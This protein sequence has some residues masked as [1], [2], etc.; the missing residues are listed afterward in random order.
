MVDGTAA[1]AL[2]TSDAAEDAGRRMQD[3]QALLKVLAELEAEFEH[4]F[5][6]WHTRTSAPSDDRPDRT[7]TS[8]PASLA[9]RQ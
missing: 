8:S 7:A 4:L 1:T 5:A 3:P 6:E 2:Q 9:A